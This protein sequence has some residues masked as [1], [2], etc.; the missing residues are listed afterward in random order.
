VASPTATPRGRRALL[1]Q[2]HV[3]V[4]FPEGTRV[5]EPDALGSP[6][7]GA[8]RLSLETGAPIVPTAIAGTSKLWF[9]PMPKPRRVRLTFLEPVFPGDGPATAQATAEV[10]DEAVWPAVREE[11]GRLA[12][13]PGPIVSALAAAGLAGGLVARRRRR[14]PPPRLLGFVES[15]RARRAKRRRSLLGRLRRSR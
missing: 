9:G 14:H 8:G 13:T 2:G 1:E 4:L 11:Y 7:H 12:A 10:I 15:R 5:D 3:V 6:H